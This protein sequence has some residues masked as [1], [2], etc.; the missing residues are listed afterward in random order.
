MSKR[1]HS[2]SNPRRG[3]SRFDKS[4]DYS[5]KSQSLPSTSRSRNRSPTSS[6]E[7]SVV[8]EEQNQLANRLLRYF[9][10]LSKEKQVI[11]KARIVKNVFD[12]QG[13]HFHPVMIKVKSILSEIFGIELAEVESNK[14][15][16]VNGI[17]NNLPHIELPPSEK[18]QLVLLFLVLSHIF[19]SEEICTEESLWNFLTK[20]GIDLNNNHHPYFGD[21]KH[22]ISEVFVSQRYLDKISTEGENDT[23]VEYKWGP[24]TKTFSRRTVFEFVSKLYGRPLKSW[25]LQYSILTTHESS[26]QS[27]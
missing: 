15:M 7:I 13:K 27:Q 22:L 20:L 25:A 5:S 3:L 4:N 2:Q 24:R 11:T 6:Y 16:L 26:Q 12:D 10:T 21:V 9:L 17:E 23:K 14:Y 1:H 8:T 19:M 18:S